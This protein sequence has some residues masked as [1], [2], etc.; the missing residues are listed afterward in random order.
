MR[1][2]LHL[3]T[4]GKEHG[5]LSFLLNWANNVHDLPLSHNEDLLCFIAYLALFIEASQQIGLLSSVPARVRSIPDPIRHPSRCAAGFALVCPLQDTTVRSLQ[6]P[7]ILRSIS[8]KHYTPPN[9]V[10]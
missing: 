5:S 9:N 3:E 8:D 2:V 6:T 10:V 4:R 1:T 7:E